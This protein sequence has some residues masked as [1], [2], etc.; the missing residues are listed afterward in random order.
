MRPAERPRSIHRAP[1]IFLI[2][3]IGAIVTSAM[4]LIVL[5]GLPN[6]FG[7]PVGVVVNLGL[8]AIGLA[9]FS[10]SC[11]L[12]ASATA[13]PLLAVVIA[14]NIGYC[15]LTAALVVAHLPDLSAW[16]VAYFVL[17]I[18]VIGVLIAAELRIRA[19]LPR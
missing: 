10:L 16:G 5:R 4:L 11:W 2:D 12:F 6:I 8:I 1:T 9:A 18:A 17:E 15:A 3:A 13:R 19:S 14:A 7:V